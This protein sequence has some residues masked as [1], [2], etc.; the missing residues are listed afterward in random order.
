MAFTTSPSTRL[1]FQ[2]QSPRTI[3][4]L[5]RSPATR[6]ARGTWASPTATRAATIRRIQIMRVVFEADSELII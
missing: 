6:R 4:H 5:P 2:A 3:G 1:I